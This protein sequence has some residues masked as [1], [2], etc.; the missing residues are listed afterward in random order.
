M[1]GIMLEISI[2]IICFIIITIILDFIMKNFILEIYKSIFFIAFYCAM[3]FKNMMKTSGLTSETYTSVALL[4]FCAIISIFIITN[5]NKIY[6]LKGIDKNFIK[7]NANKI[8]MIIDDY[9]DN[10]LDDK[11]K[12]SFIKNRIVFE[13][14]SKTQIKECLSLVGNFLDDNRKKYTIKDYL[15]Y[16]SKSIVLPVVIIA[17]IAFILIKV[18]TI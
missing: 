5:K 15:I 12:I 9:T 16:Y 8:S 4:I 11:V 1:N 14:V 17:T 18:I 6:Y 2:I 13:D 3:F 7:E 10:N